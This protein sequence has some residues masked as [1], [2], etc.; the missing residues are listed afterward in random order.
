MN[1]GLFIVL[2]SIAL[3]AG[4]VWGERLGYARGYEK[5]S[6]DDSLV[7]GMFMSALAKCQEAHDS[8]C[9]ARILPM[10]KEK[11]TIIKGI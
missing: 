1:R 2:I 6:Q 4:F 8:Q 11:E 9:S 7:L 3:I 5:A 10:K